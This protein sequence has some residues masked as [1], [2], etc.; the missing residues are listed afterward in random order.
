[1]S[2]KS[3]L[4]LPGVPQHVVQRGNNRQPCFFAEEDYRYYLECLANATKKFDCQIHAY[5]LMTNH[6]HLLVS[7][8]EEYAIFGMMQ[9]IGRKYV[10][11]VNHAYNRTGTLWEGR[12]KA[13]LVQSERYLLTCIRYIDLNP[14]CARI[15]ETPGGVIVSWVNV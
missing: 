6:V 9:S 10:R 12:F 2:R 3:R 7:S 11:Y 5:V 14:V 1:M 13:W 15:V 8:S 4:Y